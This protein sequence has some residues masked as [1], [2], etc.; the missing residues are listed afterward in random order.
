MLSYY[1]G[2]SDW[3]TEYENAVS[4]LDWKDNGKLNQITCKCP[5][6]WKV[7]HHA[8][9]DCLLQN[10]NWFVPSIKVLYQ[11]EFT[12]YFTT[13]KMNG[14]FGNS[15]YGILIRL[16]LE[17]VVEFITC[18]ETNGCFGTGALYTS[19][20]NVNLQLHTHFSR[21]NGYG[22]EWKRSSMWEWCYI[23]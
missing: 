14:C 12:T 10:F 21:W 9:H 8:F 17:F 19:E 22:T 20:D 5:V 13:G 18:G 3:A 2:L 7:L 23:T 16:F 6:V 15:A 11:C 4:C 1:G